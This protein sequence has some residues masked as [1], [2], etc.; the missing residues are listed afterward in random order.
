MQNDSRTLRM[1]RL[2]PLGLNYGLV[3][4]ALLNDKY[5][6]ARRLARPLLL[7]GD[8]SMEWYVGLMHHT[9]TGVKKDRAAARRWYAKSVAQGFRTGEDGL[10]I[11]TASEHGADV[12]AALLK[13]S[14][15]QAV[16]SDLTKLTCSARDIDTIFREFQRGADRGDPELQILLGQCY[17]AGVHVPPQWEIA[18][19]WYRRAGAQGSEAGLNLYKSLSWFKRGDQGKQET[20]ELEFVCELAAESALKG[21][22]PANDVDAFWWYFDAAQNDDLYACWRLSEF[23]LMGYGTEPN[24]DKGYEY[25]NFVIESGTSAAH[26][27]YCGVICDTPLGELVD[28][29]TLLTS[30]R[31]LRATMVQPISSRSPVR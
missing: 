29:R 15:S 30:R 23:Y 27:N 19:E 6:L 9:G 13:M 31:E 12:N 17:E 20:C 1:L 26:S 2:E 5:D 14:A 24:I 18:L 8:A 21:P 22:E 11:L 25:L 7:A 28:H 3:H 4:K 10:L 16:Y